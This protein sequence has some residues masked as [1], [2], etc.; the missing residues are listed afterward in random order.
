MMTVLM[1]KMSKTIFLDFSI[2]MFRSIHS[3]RKNPSIPPTYTTMSMIIACLKRVG[4]DEDDTIIVACDKGKSWRKQIDEQYKANRKDQREL[5]ETEIWWTEIFDMFNKLK[6]D[7]VYSSPFYII[8]ENNLEADDIISYGVRYYK[9]RECV[10][11]SSDSDFEQLAVFPN[12]KLFSPNTKKYKIIKNPY[13][14]LAKKIEK[15]TTDNLTSP[16]ITKEDYERRRAIVDLMKLPE[17]IEARIK[18]RLDG[19]EDKVFV[20]QSFP[21]KNLIPRM[22]SIYDKKDIVKFEDSFKKKKK[23]K[24]KEVAKELF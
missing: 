22:N 11:I 13:K 24:K 14:S 20:L 10:I 5:L 21:F 4:V 3:Y 16:V 6:E 9:E 18:E 2:F 15:E 19:L 7:L 23:R 8:E 12:V 1:R 17:D